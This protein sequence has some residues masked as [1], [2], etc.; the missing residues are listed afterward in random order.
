MLAS[1]WFDRDS[2]VLNYRDPA[3]AGY[4]E[5]L[6]RVCGRR[7]LGSVESLEHSSS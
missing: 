6:A 5:Y 3:T 7:R 4:A 2:S 1:T